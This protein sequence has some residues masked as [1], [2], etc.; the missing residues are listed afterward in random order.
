VKRLSKLIFI[1]VLV[2]AV[3]A[4]AIGSLNQIGALQPDPAEAAGTIITFN[5]RNEPVAATFNTDAVDVSNYTSLDIQHAIDQ[6]TVNT[7]TIKLQNSI[8]GWDWGDQLTIVTDNAADATAI[9][10]TNRIG[11]YARFNVTLANTNTI[12][13]EIVVLAE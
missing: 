9:T 8:N 11:K 4:G 10:K 1:F 13:P 6:G 2:A 3:L 5:G 12:T 7:A